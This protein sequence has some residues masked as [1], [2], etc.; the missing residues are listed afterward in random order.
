[1]KVRCEAT[2]AC[3]PCDQLELAVADGGLFEALQNMVPH[4]GSLLLM[5]GVK[6]RWERKRSRKNPSASNS[7]LGWVL[8][9]KCTLQP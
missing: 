7:L 4:I 5:E 3:W 1:M 6:G 9:E 2:M 8:S